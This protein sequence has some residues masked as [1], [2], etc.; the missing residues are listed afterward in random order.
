MVCMGANHPNE[1]VDVTAPLVESSL[2]L[3]RAPPFP[4]LGEWIQQ[5][6]CMRKKHRLQFDDDIRYL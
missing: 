2:C 4:K 3:T 5:P 6:S 1:N